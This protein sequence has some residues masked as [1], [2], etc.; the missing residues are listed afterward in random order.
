MN[1]TWSREDVLRVLGI[2]IKRRS[3]R[4]LAPSPGPRWRASDPTEALLEGHAG[5]VRGTAAMR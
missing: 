5:D 4:G 1:A 3:V 2:E